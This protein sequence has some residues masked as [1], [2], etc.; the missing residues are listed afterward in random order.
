MLMTN[1]Y[2]QQWEFAKEKNGIKVYTRPESGSNYKAFKGE[3]ELNSTMTEVTNMVEDVEQFDIWDEDI[4]EIRVLSREPGKMLRYYVVYD[5]PWPLTD[6]DLCVE[7]S[8]AVDEQTGTKLLKAI[9][10]PEAVPLVDNVVRI[11]NYWQKW[12][13]QP[14]PGGIIHLTV[15]GYADPAGDIPAWIANMAIT[16]TPLNMLEAIR[17]ELNK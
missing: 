9:S 5:L 15:E 17:D 10:I 13:I 4:S 14:G 16:D 12:I 1:S 8:I 6:R 3:I 2:A 11:V 7:A